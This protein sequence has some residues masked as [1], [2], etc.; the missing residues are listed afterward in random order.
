MVPEEQLILE[1]FRMVVHWGA[2]EA[3]ADGEGLCD[4]CCLQ[5]SQLL[6]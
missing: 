1:E 4:S 5:E 6:L 3:E 2:E